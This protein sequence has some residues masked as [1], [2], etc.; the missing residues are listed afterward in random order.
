MDE[1][2]RHLDLLSIFHYVVGAMTAL[3]GCF[4]LIHLAIGIAVVSGAMD[5]ADGPP[6][7]F[8]WFFIA[9]AAVFIT[10]AWSIAVAIVVA[11]RKLKARTA[12]TY[13]LVVAGI[14]CMFMPVGTVLGVFTLIVLMRP[15]VKEMFGVSGGGNGAGHTGNTDLSGGEIR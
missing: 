15:S 1:D 10:F 8:G 14:E 6:P 2:V 3:F 9:I 12:Y 13:C 7:E 5:D 11:G 4:P